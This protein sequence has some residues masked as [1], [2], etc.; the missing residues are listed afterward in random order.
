MHMSEAALSNIEGSGRPPAD[1]YQVII[2]VEGD[3]FDRASLHL[4]PR[5]P[6]SI[7][8]YLT[9]DATGRVVVERKGTPIHVF[10]RMRTVDD[11][12]RKLIERR[13]RGCVVPGCGRRRR[14]HVHHIKHNED[15]GLTVP[16]NLCCLC[17]AHHR[18]HHAG[19]L[20]IAGDP[21]T[22][23]GLRFTDQSG[24]L[25]RGPSPYPPGAPPH[26]AVAAAGLPA[27]SWEPP[28]CERLDGKWISWS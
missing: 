21:T 25:I 23:H 20:G 18:L 16:E 8:D 5:L 10:G 24:R 3:G 22:P 9:C 1:R 28:H 7:A 13:D 2:H 15:G 26:E 27:S 12:L 4:G 11:R 6:K 19:K 14:L 17:P